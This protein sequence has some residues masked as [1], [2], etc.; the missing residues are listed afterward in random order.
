MSICP[1]SEKRPIWSANIKCGSADLLTPSPRSAPA[2]DVGKYTQSKICYSLYTNTIRKY[3][4]HIS[5]TLLRFVENVRLIGRIAYTTVD[6]AYYYYIFDSSQI[7]KCPRYPGRGPIGV[8]DWNYDE[9]DS[10]LSGLSLY[11]Y[12]F[13]IPI[14]FK[15]N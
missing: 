6:K 3:A 7:Q 4:I 11:F 14:D 13:C 8:F 9:F 10:R 1:R 5:Y 15:T 2:I 12:L